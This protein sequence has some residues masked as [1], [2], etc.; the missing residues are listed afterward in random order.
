MKFLI[1]FLF[2]YFKIYDSAEKGDFIKGN[3]ISLKMKDNNLNFWKV[4]TQMSFKQ[5]N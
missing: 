3:K 2:C 5:Q 4:F 1:I